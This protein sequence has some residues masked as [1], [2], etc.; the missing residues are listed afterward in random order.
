MSP[1]FEL[2]DEKMPLVR[3][4]LF[5]DLPT[6]HTPPTASARFQDELVS[7]IDTPPVKP[8]VVKQGVF[9]LC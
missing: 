1:G 8:K 7:R 4:A 9:D 3:L 5:S 6:H 2:P